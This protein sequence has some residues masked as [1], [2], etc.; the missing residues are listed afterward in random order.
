MSRNSFP[1]GAFVLAALLILG[2]RVTLGES[3]RNANVWDWNDHEP[4]RSEV[5]K[6]EQ[7]AGI[8]PSPQEQQADDR[9]V[10]SLYRSLMRV[11][12]PNHS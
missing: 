11:S 9:E 8:A 4:M 5:Q 6:K 10:E 2:P 1:S 3:A 12:H 7:A